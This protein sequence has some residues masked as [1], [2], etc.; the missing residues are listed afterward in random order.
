MANRLAFLWTQCYL[1]YKGLFTWFH[2]FSYV[3]IVFATPFFTLVMFGIVGRFVQSPDAA[4]DTMIGMAV[5]SGVLI[6]VT[7]TT[8]MAAADKNMRTLE[9]NLSTNANRFFMYVNRTPVQFM[10][11]AFSMVTT[12]VTATVLVGVDPSVV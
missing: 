5:Y 7:A 9:M 2:W 1:G 6:V 11:G 3:T 10:N 4:R 8:Q 12:L